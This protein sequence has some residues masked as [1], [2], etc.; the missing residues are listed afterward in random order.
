MAFIVCYVDTNTNQQHFTK[1]DD[2]SIYKT[3]PYSLSYVF[4]E[5]TDINKREIIREKDYIY[6]CQRYG[7]KPEY[8]GQTFHHY[9]KNKDFV[10][11]GMNPKNHKYKFI[12]QYVGES[13]TYKVTSEFIKRYSS[14]V[15]NV[16]DDN[17]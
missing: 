2:V 13:N 9:A 4:R 17:D 7:L 3:A 16:S 5:D 12:I 10:L 15:P 6:G 11:V 14:L 1:T 8:L